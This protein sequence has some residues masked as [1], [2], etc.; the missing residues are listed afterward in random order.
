MMKRSWKCRLGFHDWKPTRAGTVEKMLYKIDGVV[1]ASER[2]IHWQECNDC[3]AIRK[4]A[5][6][7]RFDE[8]AKKY[9]A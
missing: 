8:I 4:D 1:S 3:D 9:C 7:N 5:N 6:R 2:V